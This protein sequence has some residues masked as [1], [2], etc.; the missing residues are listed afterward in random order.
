MTLY[1]IE[2]QYLAILEELNATEGEI[3]PEIAEK[4]SINEAELKNKAVNYALYIKKL[5]ADEKVI[6]EEISRLQELK[7]RNSKKIDSL[8]SAIVCAMVMFGVDK[9]E[10]ATLK[11]SLRKSES[12]NVSDE[13]KLSDNFF[14]TKTTRTVSKTALK[15]ALKSGAE[16][17]GAELVVNQNLQVK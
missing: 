11:L 9:V 16:I 10:T 13:S 15:D 6:S 14:T 2:Q 17:N 8:E 4:L 12:V 1:K 7:A 3:T 5:K